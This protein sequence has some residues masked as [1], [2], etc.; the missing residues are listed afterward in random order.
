MRGAFSKLIMPLMLSDPDFKFAHQIIHEK[1]FRSQITTDNE[2]LTY[3]T[4]IEERMH[5]LDTRKVL[6]LPQKPTPVKANAVNT[7]DPPPKGISKG[8]KG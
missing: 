7:G 3:F 4:Q 2:V 8:G 5:A 6:K 1:T